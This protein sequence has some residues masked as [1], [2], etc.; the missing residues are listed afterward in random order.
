MPA[1]A[2]QAGGGGVT[3][4]IL[5]TPAVG[6]Q[7]VTASRGLGLVAAGLIVVGCLAAALMPKSAVL[8]STPPKAAPSPTRA[9]PTENPQYGGATPIARERWVEGIE[10]PERHYA[11]QLVVVAFD[12]TASGAVKHCKVTAPIPQDGSGGKVCAALE[13]NA[14]FLPKRDAHG[15]AVATRG[16]VKVRFVYNE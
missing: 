2:I 14:R 15:K 11:P 8:P 5:R 9:K 16:W 12:I 7:P 3:N 4:G 10:F 1:Y 6:L 13:R